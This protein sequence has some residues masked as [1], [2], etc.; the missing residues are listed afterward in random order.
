ML[1][2]LVRAGGAARR[3]ALS[4]ESSLSTRLD[5]THAARSLGSPSSPRLPA[6]LAAAGRR[7]AEEEKAPN[8]C[9]AAFA[10]GTSVS[11]LLAA[12][13]PAAAARRTLCTGPE[14]TPEG[15]TPNQLWLLGEI[16]RVESAWKKKLDEL[17]EQSLQ[18]RRRL[19]ELDDAVAAY[20]SARAKAAAAREEFLDDVICAYAVMTMLLIAFL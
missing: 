2:H 6:T 17:Q 10:L 19:D 18:L 8:Q 20:R 4:F 1:G 3:A 5:A 7:S 13:L 11:P 9:R 12:T 14:K 15:F 16:S